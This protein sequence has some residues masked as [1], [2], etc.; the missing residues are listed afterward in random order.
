MTLYLQ[1]LLDTDGLYL[2]IEGE[3]KLPFSK[4]LCVD[5]PVEDMPIR[6][7]AVVL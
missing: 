3:E 7:L 6:S 5:G 1:R 2:H 4:R